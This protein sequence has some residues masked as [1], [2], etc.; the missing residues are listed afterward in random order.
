MRFLDKNFLNNMI[1]VKIVI[2]LHYMVYIL[3]SSLY[4]IKFDHDPFLWIWSQPTSK[5]K[6][7]NIIVNDNDD[8]M[9][10][11]CNQN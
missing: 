11:M 9:Y 8:R 5:K 1:N 3:H 6:Q 10:V 2:M 7:K 4:E